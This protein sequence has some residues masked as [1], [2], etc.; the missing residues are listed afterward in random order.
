MDRGP[1]EIG[2][3]L[4]FVFCKTEEQLLLKIKDSDMKLE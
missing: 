3:L 4:F 1:N 2:E